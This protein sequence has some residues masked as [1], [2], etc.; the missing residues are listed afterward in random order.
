MDNK[1]WQNLLGFGCPLGKERVQKE[2]EKGVLPG[3]FS[4]SFPGGANGKE[5]TS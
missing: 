1:I 4:N 2:A 5:S 3:L